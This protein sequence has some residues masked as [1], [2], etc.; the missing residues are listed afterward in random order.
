MTT[1][2]WL[3]HLEDPAFPYWEWQYLQQI[4]RF[5]TDKWWIL[6]SGVD[7]QALDEWLRVMRVLE[8]DPK[9]RRDLFLLLQAGV[10]GRAH[11][12]KLLWH[13]LTGPAV[14]PDYVDL[15]NLVTHLVY[16][17]RRTFDRP[18]RQHGDLGWWSWSC[19]ETLY[20]KDLKWHP[21]AV[22]RGPWTITTGPANEPL[23]PPAGFGIP[24]VRVPGAPAEPDKG[25]GKGA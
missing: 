8:L 18:P 14:D 10:V 20:R 11:A 3:K 21:Q 12:N 25:H 5:L 19:Y 24:E 9:A 23:P 22:P 1:L 7:K 17:A 4:H 2:G 16:R 15:S 6:Q 13:L